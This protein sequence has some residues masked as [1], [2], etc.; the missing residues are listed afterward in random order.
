M[1]TPKDHRDTV[2]G[3]VG[4]K[5]FVELPLTSKNRVGLDP[6]ERKSDGPPSIM[7]GC[8]NKRSSTIEEGFAGQGIERLFEGR[9]NS[10]DER[11]HRNYETRRHGPG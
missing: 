7:R 6:F 5:S 2:S 8:D 9:L 3:A 1:K 11:V 4:A 10:S